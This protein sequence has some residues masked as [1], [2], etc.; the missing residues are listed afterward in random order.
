MTEEAAIG[1]MT[2][3]ESKRARSATLSCAPNDLDARTSRLGCGHRCAVVVC[4]LAGRLH[5]EARAH[6]AAGASGRE[7]CAS[8]SQSHATSTHPSLNLI[9]IRAI[10]SVHRIVRLE[11]GDASGDAD[12][13]QRVESLSRSAE[14]TRNAC[15]WIQS[16]G[17]R[18]DSV[19]RRRLLPCAPMKRRVDPSS[20]LR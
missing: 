19:H 17:P 6:P 2:C 14:S 7:G 11:S 18:A 5:P 3:R 20:L 9:S 13:G 4:E 15:R 1:R 12:A 16:F 8:Q 10:S